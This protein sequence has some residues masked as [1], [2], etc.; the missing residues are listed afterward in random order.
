MASQR[1]I[2]EEPDI[3]K[4]RPGAEGICVR[5]EGGVVKFKCNKDGCGR[6]V[7]NTR[8]DIDSH[9]SSYHGK[10]SAYNLRQELFVNRP[11]CKECFKH[12]VEREFKNQNSML[13][14]YRSIHRTDGSQEDVFAQYD[15][16]H[17]HGRTPGSS[18][19]PAWTP[20]PVP[21]L[22]TS[23]STIA[24]AAGGPAGAVPAV[25]YTVPR[26]GDTFAVP[27]T[28]GVN[29]GF[30][31]FGRGALR[32]ATTAPVAPSAGTIFGVND[33][34]IMNG[35]VNDAQVNTGGPA[36]VETTNPFALGEYTADVNGPAGPVVEYGNFPS[37]GA[38]DFPDAFEHGGYG[39]ILPFPV[40]HATYAEPP[41]DPSGYTDRYGYGNNG[42]PY[43]GI[44][45]A[46]P[47]ATAAAPAEEKGFLGWLENADDTD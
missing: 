47:A 9:L 13:A 19:T 44:P 11:K 46:A 12:G 37:H 40:T 3:P 27:T 33:Y 30:A 5:V 24:N 32:G 35:P 18:T 23:A 41:F 31:G 1:E 14:H 22:M 28:M 6:C 45:A 21:V 7:Q 20:V 34:T 29:H 25:S 4:A 16:N 43:R 39:R 10:K 38:A 2:C 36:T 8:R 42:F 15:I 17:A 26:A